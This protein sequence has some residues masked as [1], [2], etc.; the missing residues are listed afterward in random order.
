ME[1]LKE[2]LENRIHELNQGIESQNL[3]DEIID[4]EDFS[5][6]KG[7]GLECT[8]SVYSNY[9][10]LQTLIDVYKTFYS[11][12]KMDKLQKGIKPYVDAIEFLLISKLKGED[13]ED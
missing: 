2:Y 13:Y 3:L 9:I 8:F 4:E 12:G 7:I 1:K 11:G 5:M 6:F 10:K